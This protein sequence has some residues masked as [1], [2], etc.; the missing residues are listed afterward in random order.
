MKMNRTNFSWRAIFR[1]WQQLL[2]IG[3]AVTAL[4]ACGPGLDSLGP[5]AIGVKVT[6]LTGTLVLQNN[7]GDDLSVTADGSLTFVT[8]IAKDAAYLVTVL[9]QPSGQICTV[10]SGGATATDKVTLVT[11]E[12]VTQWTGT[13]QLGGLGQ[14]SYGQS[15]AVDA[16]GNVY[17]VGDTTGFLDGQKLTGARD[18][19]I[20]KYNFSGVKQSTT[21]MGVANFETRGQAVAIDAG[22]NVY[23]VGYT[24]GMLGLLDLEHGAMDSVLIKYNSKGVPI[25]IRQLGVSGETTQGF[26]VAVDANFNVYVA[27][28]T[29]GPLDKSTPTDRTGTQTG[30]EDF[31][32]AKYDV[33]GKLVYAKQ[34]GATASFTDG[35]SVTTDAKGNVY[36]AGFTTGGLNGNL[37]MGTN[38]ADP[39]SPFND[40]FVA[41][42]DVGG[43][44][45]YV[46][47]QGVPGADTYGRSVAV[48]S[49]FNVYVAGD[50]TG[51][52]EFNTKVGDSEYFVTK[53]NDNDAPVLIYTNQLGVA[54]T[55][56]FGYSITIDATDNS[57]YLTGKTTATL[58]PVD[59]LKGSEDLFVAKFNGSG[60][61]PYIRQLGVAGQPTGGKSV[62]L[63]TSGNVYVA[64]STLGVLDG[65]GLQAGLSYFFVAK[66][67]RNL[68]KK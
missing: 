5:F 56:T 7:G 59:T 9:T 61:A 45:V 54:G 57:V 27:G 20:T 62:A 29:T 36:V 48:D 33:D 35:S 46:K 58:H 3:M 41:K 50:T 67:D 24:S 18:L 65:S 37:H 68:V 17:V 52:L 39:A 12:C 14:V 21:L 25:Y 1:T 55:S 32:V 47:Q 51:A 40:S 49:T 31:F 10:N 42:Y 6:G 38:V 53:Y 23:V 8:K 13:K 15:V 22:G 11:V 66:Y 63:D 43:N 30:G 4:G 2:V 64:G 19:F 60:S 16:S 34:L 26:S 44:L 28:L